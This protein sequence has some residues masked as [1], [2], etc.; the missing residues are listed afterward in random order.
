MLEVNIC[1][2]Y[3]ALG[4]VFGFLSISND[5]L[6]QDSNQCWIVVCL[7]DKWIHETWK[8]NFSGCKDRRLIVLELV[9]QMVK[10]RIVQQEGNVLMVD[11]LSDDINLWILLLDDVILEYGLCI[12]KILLIILFVLFCLNWSCLFF[13]VL[14]GKTYIWSEDNDH[15]CFHDVYSV[16][17]F[18]L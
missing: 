12:K 13:V 16:I 15:A 9:K 2:T 6:L 10:Q 3:F 8:I 18:F 7:A 4:W 17:W 5:K 14:F 11:Q 1:D